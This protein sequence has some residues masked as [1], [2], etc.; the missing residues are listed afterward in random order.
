MRRSCLSALAL[1]CCCPLTNARNVWAYWTS[2]NNTSANATP[3]V[4]G[5][6]WRSQPGWRTYDLFIASDTNRTV[7]GF[8]LGGD[9]ADR[10]WL[11]VVGGA[12]FNHPSAG[13]LESPS[14][15][16]NRPEFNLTRF[17]TYL[18]LGTL[19]TGGDAPEEIIR[20]GPVFNGFVTE[21]SAGTMHAL[22][23]RNPALSPGL[24][25][26][27]GVSVRALRI[28]VS[29]STTSVSGVI[30]VGLSSPTEVQSISIAVPNAIPA[31]GA[32]LLLLLGPALSARRRR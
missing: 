27:P 8:N 10:G 12:I 30:Q 5:T 15:M 16:Q 14:V 25:L 11:D 31:P 6:L 23:I 28:T 2:V 13:A 9:I 29:A 17:D 24:P 19:N 32:A 7:N 22:W 4:G 1:L 21:Q 18:A 20:A 3:D 26:G